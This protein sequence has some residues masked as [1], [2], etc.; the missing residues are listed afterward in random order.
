MDT[1]L[2]NADGAPLSL[3]PISIVNWELSVKLTV[4]GKVAV[5]KEHENWVIHSQALSVPVP[6]IIMMRKFVKWPKHV[7]F[8]RQ[9]VLLRDDYTCQLQITNPCKRDKGLGHNHNE[10]TMDHVNPRSFG[11]GSS[12]E[13]IITACADCNSHKG[14]DKIV[15]KK[16]PKPPSY[17]ELLEKRKNTAVTIRDVAWLDYIGW[18]ENLVYIHPMKGKRYKFKDTLNAQ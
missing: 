4:L 16:M 5:L 14:N 9:N 8:T 12:W 1:L 6:S 18:D 13:N 10:L 11:G 3:L 17:Y 7:K 15:P 2:L